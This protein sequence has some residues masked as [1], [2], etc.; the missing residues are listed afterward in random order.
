MI[1]CDGEEM[2]VGVCD[3]TELPKSI[4]TVIPDKCS[5]VSSAEV[6]SSFYAT[7]S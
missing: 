3:G 4:D 6:L 7:P 1:C 2:R 5:L